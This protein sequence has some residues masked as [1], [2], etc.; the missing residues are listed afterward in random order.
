LNIVADELATNALK[1]KSIPN[2]H[3]LLSVAS[4]LINDVQITS[5]Y[6]SI[7]R[8][9]YHSMDIREYLIHSNQW[10]D[11]IIDQIWWKVHSKSLEKLKFGKKE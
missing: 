7:I 10:N 5:N 11:K 8:K 1:L 6:A 2:N 9:I 3:K 4:L